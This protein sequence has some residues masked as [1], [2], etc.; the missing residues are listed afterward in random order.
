[1]GPYPTT[2]VPAVPSAKFSLSKA[3]LEHIGRHLLY[4]AIA[5]GIGYLLTAVI[6]QLDVTGQAA[7]FIPIAV[8]LL[9]A[10]QS[11]LAGQ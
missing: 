9:T 6:P 5:A 4:S 2:P 1:M 3:D 8:T 7:L 10:A 11:W